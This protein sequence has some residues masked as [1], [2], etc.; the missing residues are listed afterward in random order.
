MF[1]LNVYTDKVGRRTKL[2]IHIAVNIREKTIK[3][4]PEEKNRISY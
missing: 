3:K 4:R 2:I 1:E